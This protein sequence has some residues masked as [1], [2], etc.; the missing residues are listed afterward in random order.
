M[1]IVVIGI[2]G[3]SGS[4]KTLL[5]KRLAEELKS[6]ADVIQQDW[7]LDGKKVKDDPVYGMNWEVPEVMNFEGCAKAVR[8]VVNAIKHKRK[9]APVTTH[10]G[11]FDVMKTVPSKTGRVFIVVEGFLIFHNPLL[12]EVFDVGIFLA[13]PCDTCSLR[14]FL[15]HSKS[16]SSPPPE[17]TDWYSNLVWKHYL[18][19]LPA[20]HRNAPPRHTTLNGTIDAF[21]AFTAAVDFLKEA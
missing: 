2:A 15:R 12:A 4:G 8:S 10:R 19:N 17:W 14:R 9:L 7:W 5:A 1:E 21:E 11:D 18:I 13:P 20:Q 16:S 3:P 6:P